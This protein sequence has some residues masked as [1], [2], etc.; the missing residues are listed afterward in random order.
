MVVEVSLHR[1]IGNEPKLKLTGGAG[2]VMQES[3]EAALTCVRAVLDQKGIDS[4]FDVHVHLPQAAIQK[5]GPSAGLTVA[6][7]LFSAF[8]GRLIRRDVAMT[9]EITLRGHVLPVGGLREKLLAAARFGYKT[10]L[11]PAS[12]E[13][14]VSILLNSTLQSINAVPIAHFSDSLEYSLRIGDQ[15]T[16]ELRHIMKDGQAQT[17]SIR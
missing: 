14:E 5:D 11:Y 10:V 16:G 7:A 4:R 8:T 1:P 2:K 12:Q 17:V 15:S 9:G 3:V 13:K 6:I